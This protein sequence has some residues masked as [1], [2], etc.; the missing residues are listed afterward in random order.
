MAR[1]ELVQQVGESLDVL[2][3]VFERDVDQL[4]GGE[5]QNGV[6]LGAGAAHVGA[7]FGNARPVARVVLRQLAGGGVDAACEQ[8]IEDRVDRGQ[9]QAGG[10]DLVPVEGF[11]VAQVKDEA[12]ARRDRP[13]VFGAR[14]HGGHPGIA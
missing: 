5:L 8:G 13:L 14:A 11:E 9:T 1:V 3:A 7:D 4:V 2:Q 6:D 12:M 10:A